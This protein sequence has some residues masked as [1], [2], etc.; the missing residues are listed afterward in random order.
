MLLDNIIKNLQ[1]I[2]LKNNS[3]RNKVL[4]YLSFKSRI[5]CGRSQ[6]QYDIS[7]TRRSVTLDPPWILTD[8]KITAYPVE[9][10]K[11]TMIWKLRVEYRVGSGIDFGCSGSKI[12]DPTQP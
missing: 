8:Y 5:Y 3:L 9:L 7:L 2:P 1:I 10:T 11:E 4:K 6:S 12:P